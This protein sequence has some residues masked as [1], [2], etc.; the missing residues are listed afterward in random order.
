MVK[1]WPL[2]LMYS[3]SQGEKKNQ[4]KEIHL[5]KLNISLELDIYLCMFFKLLDARGRA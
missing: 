5:T 4:R 3:K 2:F 1:F